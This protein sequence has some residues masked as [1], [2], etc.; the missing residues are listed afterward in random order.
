MRFTNFLRPIIVT[1]AIF[2][3]A[4]EGRPPEYGVNVFSADTIPVAFT[5]TLTGSLALSMR[6]EGIKMQPDKSL[7]LETPAQ[8]MWARGDG[9]ARLESVGRGR[10]AVQPVGI[11]AD[12]PSDTAVVEGSVV[13]L[14]RPPER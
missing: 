7:V 10:L 12:S 4:C 11:G 5:M 2:L 9:T 8:L 13:M 6:S 3:N 14:V 1:A